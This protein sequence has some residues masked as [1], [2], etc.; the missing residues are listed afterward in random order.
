ML[1]TSRSPGC[2]YPETSGTIRLVDASSGAAANR[3]SDTPSTSAARPRIKSGAGSW[4]YKLNAA[5]SPRSWRAPQT[6]QRRRRSI[7]NSVC[8]AP[9]AKHVLPEGSSRSISTS[10]TPS[11]RHFHARSDRKRLGDASATDRDKRRFCIQPGMCSDS[12][13]TSR[14]RLAIAVV[15]LCA[16][17]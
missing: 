6:G 13:Q 5:L 16:T 15:A 8:T 14:D 1:Q 11:R 7:C 4:R 12:T 2:D 3:P 17:S 10:R 9:H